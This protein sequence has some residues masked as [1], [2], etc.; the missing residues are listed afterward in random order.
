MDSLVVRGVAGGFLSLAVTFAAYRRAALTRSG[1]WAAAVTGVVLVLAGWRWLALV[2]AFFISS[3]VLTRLEGSGSMVRRSI[4]RGGRRWQQVAANGGIAA[5]C[6]A[7]TALT[8]WPQGFVVAAGA[9]AAATADTWATEIGRWSRTPPRLITTGRPVEP[10]VSGGVTA[11]G[12]LASVG[13]AM[14]IAALAGSLNTAAPGSAGAARHAAWAA[15]IA[16]GGIT[17]SLLDSVL[18]ATLED[19]VRGLNN[20][21]VN[22]AAT[23]WGAALVLY[24]TRPY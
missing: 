1:A 14:F 11:A 4:D 10:G 18:G 17:G 23:I 22:L 15:W 13:G 5:L 7:G 20:D 21:T 24:A 8:G 2:G 12:T 19:R 3:S 6:A 9:I 16:V